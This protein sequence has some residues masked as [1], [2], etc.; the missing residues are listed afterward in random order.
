M[1]FGICTSL[2]NVNRLAE[3]GYD[4]IEL[5]VRSALIPEQ[6]EDDFQKIKERVAEA[7][8]KPEAYAGFIPGDLRVVGTT[9]DS[10][11]LSRYVET[12]CR[13]ASE[14]GGEIIVYGSSGSRNLEEGYS[15]ERALTQIAEFLDMAADHAETYG[16]IIVVEPICK[17][18]GNIIRTV[19]D[20][21]AMAKRVNR[22]GI[23]ALA[24]LYHIWQENEPL[25][26]IVDAADWL[27]HVHIAEP[28]KRSYPGNDD[29]DFT[30]FFIALKNAGYEGRISCECKFDNFHIDAETAYKTLKGYI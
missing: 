13:R 17:K 5:G 29:F 19:A 10:S 23:K 4:Y 8:L 12:A 28:V 15:E 21:L 20:G 3:V 9:V 30:D 2:D 7:P 25:Q 27:A 1:R 6:T 18:E 16:I 22:K 24:D 26:N 11:R 14:I